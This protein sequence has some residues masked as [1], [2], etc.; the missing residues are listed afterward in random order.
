LP[1]FNSVAKIVSWVETTLKGH[2]SPLAPPLGPL[3]TLPS[4]VTPMTE[5][6]RIFPKKLKMAE[7][8]GLRVRKM[9]EGILRSSLLRI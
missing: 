6:H 3:A 5:A 4:Q 1:P 7:N 2:L 8:L 9:L